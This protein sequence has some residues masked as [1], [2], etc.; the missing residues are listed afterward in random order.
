MRKAAVLLVTV[1]VVFI[2]LGI[3]MIQSLVVVQR[4]ATVSEVVPPVWVKTAASDQF[5]PL[6]E[7]A[8]V[9]AG[10]LVKTGD[11]G[12]ATLNWVDGS[13]IRLA[14]ATSLKVLKCSLN[15]NNGAE[16]SLFHLD[17][18][19]VWVRI[20]QALGERSK[21]EIRT[22]TATAGVRG[23]VF[24]LAVDPKGETHVS[25][26]EG[27]VTLQAAGKTLKAEAGQDAVVGRQAEPSKRTMSK[28]EAATW[29]KQTGIIGPR[30][31]VNSPTTTEVAADAETVTVTGATEPAATVTVNGRPAKLDAENAFHVNLPF[32]G[33]QSQLRV[34][35]TAR[36]RRGA[37]TSQEFVLSR[38]K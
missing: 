36:D 1:L 10:N 3:L 20:L 6:S 11:G 28:A 13:R 38:T 29:A 9:L 33:D 26:Y 25:V 34:V 24:S 12:Q 37:E 22:P 35:V 15:K 14:P 23:T 21:F 4:I 19:R 32:A 18:G 30:L 7:G 31:H 5:K 17:V 2:F 27:T 16:T 8:H